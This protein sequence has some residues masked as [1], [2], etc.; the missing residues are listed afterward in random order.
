MGLV[1]EEA[2]HLAGKRVQIFR[3]ELDR[4]YSLGFLGRLFWRM[5]YSLEAF[6]DV[7]HGSQLSS[8]RFISSHPLYRRIM[9]MAASPPIA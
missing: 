9:R 8:A 6:Q 5:T 7:A 2:W 1:D 3:H 4:Y